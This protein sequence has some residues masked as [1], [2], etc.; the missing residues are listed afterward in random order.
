MENLGI[1]SN[2]NDLFRFGNFVQDASQL[3]SN[4]DGE[5]LV[6]AT[7]LMVELP[8]STRIRLVGGARLEST[9]LDVISQ[10]STKTEGRLDTDDLLPSLNAV[11]A[12]NERMN[13]RASYGRTLL[14]HRFVSS[15]RLHPSTLWVISYS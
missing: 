2:E 8:L 6:Y 11:Y 13:L 14:V 4:F 9:D 15:H 10:D 12:L 1:L 3:S 7:Y 5:Q